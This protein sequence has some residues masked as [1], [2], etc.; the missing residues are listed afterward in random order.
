MASG[1]IQQFGSQSNRIFGQVN[2]WIGSLTGRNRILGAS[3]NELTRQIQ[4]VEASLRNSR[5]A[6]HIRELR[7]ELE[8]LQQQR[9]RI[10]GGGGAGGSR[11][12]GGGFSVGNFVKGGLVLGAVQQLGSKALDF[13]GDSIG[14][15][16]E[17]QKVQTSF[18][19]LT[20]SEERGQALTKQLVDLQKNTILDGEVFD[21]AKTMLSFGLKDSE[22]LENMKMLGDISMGDKE[23]LGSLTLAFSQMSSA[24]KLTGQDLLQ[25]INAGFNPLEEMS[26]KTGKSMT[27]LRK[28]M[29]QGKISSAMVKDAFKSA[30]GEGGRF[31]GMLEK[32]AETPAGKMAQLSGAWD[33]FK[34]KA[35]G[36]LMPLVS[37]AM[38]FANKLM[39]VAE[40]LISPLTAGVQTVVGWLQ[41]A[42]EW[43]VSLF[44]TTGGWSDYIAIVKQFIVGSIVPGV[45][46]IVGYVVHVVKKLAEFIGKSQ[47][48][49]DIFSFIASVC[50]MMWDVIGWVIDKVKW[51]F[52]NV[53]MP[54]LN[55]IETVYRFLKGGS[56]VEVK[57]D[58]DG[59]VTVEPL[60]E[61]KKTEE[62]TLD[63]LSDIS[64]N[65]KEN[66]KDTTDANAA[67]ASGGPRIVNITV[68][69][70]LDS[71]VINTTNL[72]ESS[73]DVQRLFMELFGRVL[74][75][76]AATL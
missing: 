17:R 22:V 75:G 13:A 37:M 10:S 2:Q 71:I 28:E 44:T 59:T 39:P 53:I 23:K 56:K 60:P 43:L 67:I 32:I 42:Y 30:T 4:Q 40:A 31:N 65:T 69:K 74:A 21:N 76:G 48:L 15:N 58:K 14:K 24:G 47:L 20:G 54:I 73:A 6:A 72:P 61:Q 66:T 7:R 46:K 63:T 33:E 16:M 68:P 18:S 29:E 36:A 38:E 27:M 49:K 19:V 26:R 35:G 9:N 12:G 51:L 3:Y 50:S 34:I 57:A 62:K 64:K 8:R 1:Q 41:Q 52:D 5:S 25:M 45:Q 55:A 70:F 11:G